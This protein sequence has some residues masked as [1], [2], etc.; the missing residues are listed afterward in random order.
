M[1]FAA[2]I[3][4][5][6]SAVADDIRGC[7]LGS[8]GVRT[9][10][11]WLVW[12]RQNSGPD[13]D[14]VVREVEVLPTPRVSLEGARYR[15]AEAGI[16]RSGE[17]YVSEISLAIPASLLRGDDGGRLPANVR[18]CWELRPLAD[19]TAPT[20]VGTIGGDPV[21]DH[22]AAEQRVSLVVQV[23]AERGS[24]GQGGAYR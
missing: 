21:R 7:V 3:A 19:A 20:I 11:V 14:T 5:D 6:L 13:G 4:G 8:F 15:Y 10:A 17:A 23:K 9:H 1:D 24:V 22:E 16:V 2:T 18:F 12:R